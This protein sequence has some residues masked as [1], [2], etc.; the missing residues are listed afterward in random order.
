[1]LSYIVYCNKINGYI[2]EVVFAYFFSILIILFVYHQIN[3]A[4]SGIIWYQIGNCDVCQG[5]RFC[6]AFFFSR[7]I[8]GRIRFYQHDS[9]QLPITSFIECRIGRFCTSFHDLTICCIFI[10]QYMYNYAISQKNIFIPY[11]TS[12]MSALLHCV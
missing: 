6:S 5:A 8:I 2:I 1:M 7:T 4:G 11:I 10:Q 12:P 9:C 3:L